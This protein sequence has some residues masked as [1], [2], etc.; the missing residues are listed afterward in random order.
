M[1]HPGSG[2]AYADITMALLRYTALRLL[3]F[4]VVVALLWIVGLRGF[5]LLLFALLLSGVVSLFV[6]NR[7]RD[8]V[9]TALVNRQQR[10][11]QRMVERTAAEDAWNDDVRDNAGPDRH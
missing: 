5:V 11:K 7:S 10:I 3:I 2:Q 9:S 6:L 4:V 8:A 1:G